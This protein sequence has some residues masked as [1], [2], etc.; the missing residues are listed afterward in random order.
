MIQ[1]VWH[2]WQS[3]LK[4]VTEELYFEIILCLQNKTMDDVKVMLRDAAEREQQL[5][6]D[7]NELSRKVVVF[8]FFF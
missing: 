5:I 6:H 3:F 4:N 7:N 2:W 8:L 1:R